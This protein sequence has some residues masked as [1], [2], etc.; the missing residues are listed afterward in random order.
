MLLTDAMLIVDL[1]G[2]FA[3]GAS[4]GHLVDDWR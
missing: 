2:L 1:N 3:E 4:N